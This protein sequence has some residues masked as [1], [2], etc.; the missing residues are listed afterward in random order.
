MEKQTKPPINLYLDANIFLSFYAL[1]NADIKQ[2]KLLKEVVEN[3]FIQLFV[4]DQLN[5]E[6]ERNRDNKIQESFKALMESTFKIQA[7]AFV[8]SLDEYTELQ[9]ILKNANE[10][11]SELV[12]KV[13]E[14]FKNHELEADKIILE[15]IKVAEVV[16][17]DDKQFD[18][19]YVRFLKGNPPGKK[20]TTI[21]DELNWEFLLSTVP[22]KE[23]LHLVSADRDYAS[24]NVPEQA[25]AFLT[26][27][28]KSVKSAELHF[29]KDLN[30]F[31]KL[32]VPKIKLA[33]QEKLNILISKLSGSGSFASTHAIIAE[34]PEDPEF[35]DAQIVELIN[36]KNNNSQVG[37][38]IEDPDVSAFYAQIDRKY[39][40][41]MESNVEEMPSF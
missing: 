4:S 11:H 31:F 15:L 41:R 21:G 25:N 28:W 29:Y 14:L 10:K 2:L 37:W 34:F 38:I 40:Q 6:I 1:S 13:S 39:L 22:N 24:P 3:R 17:T 30:E 23:D 36:I 16:K 9:S 33:N 5:N 20:K 8:K 19:A 32:H 7:P 27:E 35:N 26:K 12:L 18:A